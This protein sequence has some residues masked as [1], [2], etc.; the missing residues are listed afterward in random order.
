VNLLLRFYDYKTGNIFLDGIDI[1]ELDVNFL[2]Q[3][4]GTVCQEPVLFSGSI[5]DNISI[6]TSNATMEE[7]VQAAQLANAHDFIVSL[8]DVIK[9]LQPPYKN[10]GTKIKR[11]AV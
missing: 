3:Q 7:V 2:R 5:R 9:Y 6:G 10:I 1:R 4:I 11:T 8:P